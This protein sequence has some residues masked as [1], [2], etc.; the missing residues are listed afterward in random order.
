MVA[1]FDMSIRGR[2]SAVYRGAVPLVEGVARTRGGRTYTGLGHFAVSA[3][4]VLAFVPG[5]VSAS[6]VPLRDLALYDRTGAR[7]PLNLPAMLYEFPRVSPNGRQI[8]V[9][10]ADSSNQNV[11]INDISGTS[12]PG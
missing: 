5:P 11:W 9:G 2:F 7:E 6:S 4:G 10:S 12:S 8:A 1:G 3:N